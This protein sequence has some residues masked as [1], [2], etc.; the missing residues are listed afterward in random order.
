[1]DD[2]EETANE[3]FREFQDPKETVVFVAYQV[4]RARK[5][6]AVMLGRLAN[7]VFQVTRACRVNLAPLESRVS[8]ERWVREGSS[9]PVGS[10]GCQGP[11]ASLAARALPG[12]K[13]TRGPLANLGPLVTLVPPDQLVRP[14]LKVSSGR[15][16]CPVPAASPV[17]LAWPGLMAYQGTQVTQAS[18][19]LRVTRD[20]LD[21]RVHLASQVLEE[22]RVT[23]ETGV[24][25]AR[26]AT[27]EN[28]A[29][30]ALR[31]TW[32]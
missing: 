27:R 24:F 31:A 26:R 3:A 11:L 9:V 10:P 2:L 14:V 17:Y 29:L 32:E 6:I 30:M 16:V 28:M 4:C 5:V 21:H 15:L 19:A 20:L 22:S 18:S 13:A 7:L 12:P 8:P 25:R 23:R 1:M